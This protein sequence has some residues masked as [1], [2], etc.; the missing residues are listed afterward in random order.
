M[1]TGKAYDLGRG[2][3]SDPVEGIPQYPPG[4]GRYEISREFDPTDKSRGLEFGSENARVGGPDLKLTRNNDDTIEI[5]LKA[6]DGKFEG[7]AEFNMPDKSSFK[8]YP[9][10]ERDPYKKPSTTGGM[11]TAK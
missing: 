2:S 1:Y 5:M 8:K 10:R 3:R 4:A 6:R 9:F 11:K 7:G